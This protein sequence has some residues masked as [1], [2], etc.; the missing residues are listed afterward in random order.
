MLASMMSDVMNVKS[1]G[2]E[3]YAGLFITFM[4]G[5]SEDLIRQIYQTRRLNANGVIIFD[6]AHTTPVYTTTLMA[7][8]FNPERPKRT[9][10]AE[11]KKWKIFPWQKKRTQ[12]R[13]KS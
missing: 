2:T 13:E 8:V 3:L 1:E 10:I 6:Y 4:G 5:A 12:N 9:I 11:K 7:S